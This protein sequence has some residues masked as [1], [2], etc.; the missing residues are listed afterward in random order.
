MG[1]DY[2]GGQHFNHFKETCDQ[3]L[4]T[5]LSP[6]IGIEAQITLW[7]FS[8]GSVPYFRGSMSNVQLSMVQSPS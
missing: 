7:G 2:I 1:L 5:H 8:L 3:K 6:L 4:R